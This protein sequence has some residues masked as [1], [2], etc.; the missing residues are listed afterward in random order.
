MIAKFNPSG[1][2]EHK[3]KLKIRVD[4]YPVEASKTFASQRVDKLNRELTD[5]ERAE[6][7]L[8]DGEKL[9]LKEQVLRKKIGTH[10]ELNPCLCHFIAIDEG[11]TKK[12]LEGY[13][14]SIFSKDTIDE[15][16]DALDKDDRNKV[17]QTMKSKC[18][19]GK[20]HS[21]QANLDSINKRFKNL[22]V[23][24]GVN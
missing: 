12:E 7:D 16:D 9:K 3:G 21:K 14:Q 18:G 4:I 15:L 1:T 22:E 20:I 19:N 23:I 6:F 11:M 13:V 24:V 10:K 8:L 5:K 2:H 17:S